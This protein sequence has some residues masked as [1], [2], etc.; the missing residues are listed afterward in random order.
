ML[1]QVYTWPGKTSHPLITRSR[2]LGSRHDPHMIRIR[3]TSQS[4]FRLAE[5][6]FRLIRI[7]RRRGVFTGLGFRSAGQIVLLALFSDPFAHGVRVDS[8]FFH[9]RGRRFSRIRN[10]ENRSFS[11]FFR[12]LRVIAWHGS[13]SSQFVPI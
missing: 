13:S 11:H 10:M 2:R 9:D 8:E 4:G 6:P 5:F 3:S 12:I 1:D 7:C